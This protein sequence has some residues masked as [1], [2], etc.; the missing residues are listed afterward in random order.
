VE[1]TSGYI[2]EI[3]PEAEIYYLQLS[4]HLYKTHSEQSAERK[5]DKILDIAMS[6]NN[7]PYRGRVEDK[8]TFSNIEHRFLLYQY[9]SR[10]SIKIIYF[11]DESSRT[12]YVTDFFGTEMNDGK[13][14]H[15]NK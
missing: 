2:V 5:A 11:I 3:T 14:A 9:T 13:I 1:E 8:L 15:R 10:K 6:L 12:V 7:N 4:E